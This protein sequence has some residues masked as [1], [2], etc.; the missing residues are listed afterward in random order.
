[1]TQWLHVLN[2]RWFLYSLLLVNSF[3]TVYGY[4]W[5]GWQLRETPARFLLFVPDSPMASHFFVFVILAFLLRRHWPL[6]EA[7]AAVT[8]VK[9]GIWA[10]V[11]NLLVLNVTGELSW[12]GYMLIASHA[13]MAIQGM[14]YA[15]YYRFKPWHLIAAAVWTL[16]NDMIDFLYKMMPR[17]PVLDQ[18]FV[19]IG[20]FTFWLSMASIWVAY[21]LCLRKNRRT[22]E[23]T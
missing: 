18:Y 19:P 23:L 8:L 9:Y 11:M 6:I 2:K 16:H 20:Y 12:Q 10:V 22:L 13:A 21:M 7:L 17:Y 15:P 4:V 14:L 1:M 3:G 5:Y